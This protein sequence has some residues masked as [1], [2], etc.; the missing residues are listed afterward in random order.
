MFETNQSKHLRQAISTEAEQTNKQKQF[1]AK[2]ENIY[3]TKPHRPGTNVLCYLVLHVQHSIVGTERSHNGDVAMPGGAVQ[4]RL[5]QL[6]TASQPAGE[7][8][9]KHNVSLTHNILITSMHCRLLNQHSVLASSQ[10]WLLSP[11]ALL[12]HNNKHALNWKNNM[13]GNFFAT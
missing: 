8:G 4:G 7:A 11:P 13:K 12:I 9:G 1:V 3:Q 2:E 6:N 5:S 10:Y